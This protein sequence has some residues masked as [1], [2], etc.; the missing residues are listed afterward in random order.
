MTIVDA[1]AAVVGAALG[2]AN[3]WMNAWLHSLRRPNASAAQG[4]A[5]AGEGAQVA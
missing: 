1:M 4:K 5:T 2:W 3:G